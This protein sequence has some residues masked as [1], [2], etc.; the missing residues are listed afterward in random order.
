MIVEVKELFETVGDIELLEGVGA[1]ENQ[2]C[3]GICCC[4]CSCCCTS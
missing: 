4:C 1:F 2:L 3:E